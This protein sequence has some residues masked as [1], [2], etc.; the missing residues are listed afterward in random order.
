MLNVR[1]DIIVYMCSRKY[2]ATDTVLNGS[3]II[4]KSEK[5]NP[6]VRALLYSEKI[7]ETKPSQASNAIKIYR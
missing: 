4:T 6:R 5:N 2:Q 7:R 3:K 1:C